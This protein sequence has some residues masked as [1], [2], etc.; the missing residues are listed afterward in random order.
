MI[1]KVYGIVRG[2]TIEFNE[3]LGFPQGERVEV[4]IERVPPGAE[5]PTPP[6]LSEGLTKIYGILGERYASGHTDTAAR[7]NEHQP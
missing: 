4:A 5:E 3:D 2:N 7:H 6:P 1:K